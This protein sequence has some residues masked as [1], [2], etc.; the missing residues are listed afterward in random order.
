MSQASSNVTFDLS[1]VAGATKTFTFPNGKTLVA[2]EPMGKVADKY[3]AA[4]RELGRLAMQ[5]KKLEESEDTENI[6]ELAT[7]LS[8]KDEK[9][10]LDVMVLLFSESDRKEITECFDT[11]PASMHSQVVKELFSWRDSSSPL[12]S[13]KKTDDSNKS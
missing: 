6:I 3:E 13:L 2:H 12:E 5:A 9:L 10:T 1:T 7:E 8:N 11:L 4:L